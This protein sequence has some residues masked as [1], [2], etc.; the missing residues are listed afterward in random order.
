MSGSSSGQAGEN[1][2]PEWLEV[3]GPR[4]AFAGPRGRGLLA[5]RRIPQD[6]LRTIVQSGERVASGQSTVMPARARGTQR[7]QTKVPRYKD[8]DRS[9]PH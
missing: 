7:H 2:R 5:L 9:I 1:I 8:P 3:A 6:L 4:E